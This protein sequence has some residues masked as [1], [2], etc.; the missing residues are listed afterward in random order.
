MAGNPKLLVFTM[1]F[2]LVYMICFYFNWGLFRFYPAYTQFS[3]DPLGPEAGPVIMWYG[4][5]GNAFIVATALA[6]L[7]PRSIA[8]KLNPT[9]VWGISAVVLIGTLW[10]EK[11]WF[12]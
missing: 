9:L 6:L 3:F 8:M 11:R 10:Y 12:I 1:F 4:W 7:T 2:G 5:M